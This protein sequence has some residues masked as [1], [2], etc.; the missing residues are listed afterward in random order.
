MCS[1]HKLFRNCHANSS[2]FTAKGRQ[3]HEETTA[4]SSN[5]DTNE[6]QVGWVWGMSFFKAGWEICCQQWWQEFTK[7][8]TSGVFQYFLLTEKD[9]HDLYEPFANRQHREGELILQP[10]ISIHQLRKKLWYTTLSS[11]PSKRAL[12]IRS[13]T[14]KVLFS[15]LLNI[16]LSSLF[17]FF[18]TNVH[19]K[20]YLRTTLKGFNQA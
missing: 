12:L 5:A 11:S 15:L 2:H 3:L 20:S 18:L 17:F 10:S 19:F 6:L 14:K 4:T 16:H 7:R 1:P 13:G 9:L 8:N